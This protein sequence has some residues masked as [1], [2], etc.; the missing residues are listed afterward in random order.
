MIKKPLKEVKYKD[1]WVIRDL[2]IEDYKA[3]LESSKWKTLKK[4]LKKLKKNQKCR[5]CGR[6]GWVQLHHKTYRF[7]GTSKE[8]DG[9][10]AMCGKCHLRTHRYAK[11]KD[12]SVLRATRYVIANT[13]QY[14]P[15]K[16]KK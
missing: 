13:K 15:K 14:K 5:A 1:T 2:R 7:V 11:N 9:I 3:Y 4:E 8:Q 10:V 16:K 12:V 6:T